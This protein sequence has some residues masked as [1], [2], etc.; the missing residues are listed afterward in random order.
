MQSGIQPT[1]NSQPPT[2]PNGLPPVSPPSGKFIVQLFLVP[3]LIVGLIVVLLLIVHWMFGGPRNPEAILK[4]LDD[5]N[6]EV[7]WREA[8]DLAQILPRDQRLASDPVFGLQLADRLHKALA[9]SDAA[10]R[11]F[12]EQLPK[13][14][15][16]DATRLRKPLQLDRDY[17]SYLAASLGHFIV[18]VGLPVLR[19]MAEQEAPIEPQVQARRRRV[20]ILSLAKLG[21]N[22]KQFEKMPT[23]EQNLILGKLE[24]GDAP[25]SLAEWAKQT[26]NYLKQRQ[27][28]TAGVFGVDRT[29]EKCA[30][31]DDPVLRELVAFASN[32]WHGSAEENARIEKTLLKLA[33]DAGRG[34]DQSEKFSGPEPDGSKEIVRKPGLLVRINATIALANRGSDKV[35]VGMLEEM[36]DEKGLSEQIIS[37][38]KDGKELP[39][40]RKAAEIVVQTLK[41][42]GKLHAQNPKVNLDRLR[43]LVQGLTSSDNANV[44]A[45]AQETQ[46]ILSK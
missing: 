30:D 12:A 46:N 42:I 38:E 19:Q 24:A 27:A 22:L 35:N 13:L 1:P 11:V 17:V 14:S 40:Q 43:P 21:E 37:R 31:A 36:L 4:K 44:Q 10:E 9:S 25:P 20:A 23:I 5:S 2:S 3:G 16:A 6:A 18:P 39:D 32:T 45:A 33:N 7:R 41:A 34:E 8:A 26:L 29:L 15:E 28:G